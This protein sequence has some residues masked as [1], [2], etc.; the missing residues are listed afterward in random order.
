M[1]LPRREE[2]GSPPG[3][4]HSPRREGHDRG[5]RVGRGQEMGSETRVEIGERR[6]ECVRLWGGEPGKPG[7]REEERIG[8]NSVKTR[9]WML[10][11]MRRKP[12]EIVEDYKLRNTIN[13]TTKILNE[14]ET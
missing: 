14:I 13:D 12:E 11:E 3:D 2:P 6:C 7:R 9:E 5:A 10:N 8:I 1:T 4:L